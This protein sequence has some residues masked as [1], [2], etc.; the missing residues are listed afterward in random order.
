MRFSPITVAFVLC[1]L[2]HQTSQ[3]IIGAFRPELNT[4]VEVVQLLAVNNP[5]DV[6]TTQIRVRASPDSDIEVDFRCVDETKNLNY[7]ENN[8]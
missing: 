2:A 3:T 6:D 7:T 1:T 8:A 4:V 5:P